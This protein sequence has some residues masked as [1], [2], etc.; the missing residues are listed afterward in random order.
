LRCLASLAEA[1][2]SADLLTEA[3]GLLDGADIPAGRAWLLGYESY[4]SLARAWLDRDEPDQA[5]SVLVPLIEV[6]RREPWIT[7][8]AAAL[9]VDGR[10]LLRLGQRTLAEDQ[11]QTAR[12]LAD[13]HALGQVRRDAEDAL[14]GAG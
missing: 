4:L 3:A 9:A 10:A 1:S 6:A 12:Q 5:R 2:G 14:L 8:L 11:L 13:K 7:A